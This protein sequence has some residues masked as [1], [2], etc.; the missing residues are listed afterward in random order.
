M[1]LKVILAMAGTM[2]MVF[3]HSSAAEQVAQKQDYKCYLETSRGEQIG[4][5]RW[6]VKKHTFLAA[7]LV[8]TQAFSNSNDKPFIKEVVECVG[9][10]DNFSNAKAQALDKATA[11]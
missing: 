3:S 6:P 10:D 11:R 8:G 5:Y 4:F 2:L 1:K 7:R 9:L